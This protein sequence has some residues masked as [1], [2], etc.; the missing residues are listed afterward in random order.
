ML[1]RKFA[2]IGIDVRKNV[3]L[4]DYAATRDGIKVNLSDGYSGTFEKILVAVGR[5]P[6]VDGVG[7][8]KAGVAV[9]RK[10]LADLAVRDAAAFN[11]LADL[12]K[13]Q[14]AA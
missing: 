1:E 5:R 8:R 9:D 2:R 14:A 3:L 6:N 12:V 13:G 4:S 7:L 10:I 11:A